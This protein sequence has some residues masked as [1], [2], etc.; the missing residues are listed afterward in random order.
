MAFQNSII[1][2]G[3]LTLQIVLN[4]LGT[5][6]VAAQTIVGKTDQLAMLPMINFGQAVSTFTA[7]NYGAKKYHRLFEGLRQ[8]LYIVVSWAIL[9]G[10]ILIS[11]DRFFSGLF[12]ANPSH[13]ILRLSKIAYV[14]NGLCYWILA[15]LFVV[16]GF[17]QGLGKS[18]VP[19][20]AGIMELIMRVVI[21]IVGLIYIGYEGVIWA[22][23]GAWIGS[24]VILIPSA[25]IYKKHL[26]R[27]T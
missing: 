18:F 13:E 10:I 17:I 2:I 26:M 5:D 9:F 24:V 11:F 14:I 4:R 1:A 3:T 25:L 21:S 15:I 23:P 20:I 7:Q 19:T 16:R 12:V 27:Y 8:S 22:S 6:A